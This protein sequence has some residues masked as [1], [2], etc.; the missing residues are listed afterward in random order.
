MTQDVPSYPFSGAKFMSVLEKGH[1]PFKAY[2][3]G[4]TPTLLFP[5]CSFP[6]Q[7]PRTTDALVQVCR[8]HGAG[9]AY[10][11]CAR[12]AY[13]WGETNLA[14]KC[15]AKLEQRLARIGVRRVIFV[16][17]DCQDY[18]EPRLAKAGIQSVSVYQ[19]LKEWDFAPRGHIAAGEGPL[20]D[21]EWPVG[22]LFIPCP[23]K[24]PGSHWNQDIASYMDISA[25]EPLQ[26]PCCGLKPSVASKGP[27]TIKKLDDRIFQLTD[28]R[29]LYTSCASCSGQFARMGYGVDRIVHLT[30][31]ALGVHEEPDAVHALANRARRKFDKNL[32][33]LVGAKA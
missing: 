20:A 10:D 26:A 13:Y 33:P 3:K 12:S 32:E 29:P 2:P 6:S 8:E 28:D 11:C 25:L 1:Y 31:V 18:L 22:A 30:S 14:E 27:E 5:G 21:D 17:P 23:A 9:V 7:F 24:L 15:E 4:Q 16:C 19:Q